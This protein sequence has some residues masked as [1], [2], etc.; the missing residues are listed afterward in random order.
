MTSS[1]PVQSQL[2]CNIG[3]HDTTLFLQLI[4][5]LSLA[6]W[7]KKTRMDLY[8]MY[9]PFWNLIV[10]HLGRFK[11]ITSKENFSGGGVSFCSYCILKTT[12]ALTL[13]KFW[14]YFLGKYI[15]TEEIYFIHAHIWTAFEYGCSLIINL[16]T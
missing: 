15:V 2:T 11:L 1:S 4:G 10:L 7:N 14:R 9:V 6:F 16:L 5:R 13:S 8:M 12:F 3:T